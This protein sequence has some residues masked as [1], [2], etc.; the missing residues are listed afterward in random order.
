ML[1]GFGYIVKLLIDKESLTKCG[2]MHNYCILLMSYEL[3]F[4][5]YVRAQ[6]QVSLSFS[7][8]ILVSLT[9]QH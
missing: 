7:I 4:T 9:L 8:V 5:Y 6:K 2:P 3:T 1:R